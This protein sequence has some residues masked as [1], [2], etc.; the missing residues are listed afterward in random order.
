MSLNRYSASVQAA[1]NTAGSTLLSVRNPASPQR[2]FQLMEFCVSSPITP[3]DVTTS[4]F[5]QHMSSIASSTSI[6]GA[7]LDRDSAAS[8]LTAASGGN[9]TPITPGFIYAV[10]VNQ[11]ASW[12]WVA[13][14]NGSVIVPATAN[15]GVYL[16]IQSTTG[17]ATV[18][19]TI[20]W[21]E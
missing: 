1:A 3:V 19:A 16:G 14:P 12:R 13:Q 18:D 20:I 8:T 10:S 9:P 7:P 5:L 4:Y 11:R 21:A 17:T 2:R 6:N 15:N